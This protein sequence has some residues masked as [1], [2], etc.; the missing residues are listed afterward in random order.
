M[1]LN[2]S[3]WAATNFA[4]I[5]GNMHDGAASPAAFEPRLLS[6]VAIDFEQNSRKTRIRE[7][8]LVQ[9]AY[10]GFVTKQER[11][12]KACDQVF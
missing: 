4:R 12:S 8:R 10:S 3:P 6:Q 7:E 2:E 5:V 1:S 11:P 9:G